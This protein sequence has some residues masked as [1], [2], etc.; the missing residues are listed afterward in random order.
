MK[1][2]K[3]ILLST[4]AVAAI[5]VSVS[6]MAESDDVNAKIKQ[7]FQNIGLKANKIEDSAMPGLK[8]VMTNRGVFY[9]SDDAKFFVA[10][11][12]FSIEDGLVN[13]TEGALS[14]MRLAGMDEFK[15]SMIVFPAKE[16]KHTI[17]VFTD[18][19]CT[20][21]QRLHHQIA[22]YNDLGITVRYMAF[23]RGGIG[24]R[25]FGEVS[26]VWCAKD[27]QQA[28]TQ[29]KNG[30]RLTPARCDAPIIGHYE[31]GQ[32]TGVTGTPAIILDDGS[33]ISGYKPPQELAA[34]L[35]N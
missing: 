3:T 16:Q 2:L 17:T 21:C 23:P 15:D 4:F 18:T 11:R 31:L 1:L 14:D 28:M 12:L 5:A 26:S 34:Q 25:S 32:A 24:S 6:S 29:A 7:R 30:N 8:Q 33:M 9:I 27:Q 22:E 20:F 13:L 35:N 10:G 19:T